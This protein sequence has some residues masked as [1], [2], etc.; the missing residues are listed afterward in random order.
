[1]RERLLQELGTLNEANRD[2]AIEIVDDLLSALNCAGT[3]VDH[4]KDPGPIS[5]R[6]RILALLEQAAPGILDSEAG[7]H[8]EA[9][10][11]ALLLHVQQPVHSD[12]RVGTVNS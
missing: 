11:N 3:R 1:M 12:G 5:T 6:E 10:V 4:L 7:P 2:F 9:T 8:V